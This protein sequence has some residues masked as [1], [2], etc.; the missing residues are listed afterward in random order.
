M[1]NNVRM[2]PPVV[3]RNDADYLRQEICHLK[4]DKLDL[5]KQN[6]VSFDMDV[7]RQNSQSN[8]SYQYHPVLTINLRGLSKCKRF[9][10]VSKD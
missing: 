6:I 2:E 8:N 1:N 3:Q 9:T 7:L 10:F 4:N 5:L